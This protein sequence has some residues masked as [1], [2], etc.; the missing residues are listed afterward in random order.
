MRRGIVSQMVCVFV[1]AACGG[2]TTDPTAPPP[3][4]PPT[5]TLP[6]PTQPPVIHEAHAVSSYLIGQVA[7]GSGPYLVPLHRLLMPEV[8]PS[9][10]EA[11]DMV[12]KGETFTEAGMGVSTEIPR[13]TEL[14]GVTVADGLA[15]IDL[16]GQFDDGS[17]SMS[18][19]ARLAQV[20]YTAT[21]FDDIERVALAIESLPVTAFSAEGIDLSDPMD[22]ETFADLRNP[23][24]VEAPAWGELVGAQFTV[25]GVTTADVVS[26]ALVDW[27]GLILHE[28]SAEL[29]ATEGW[30]P[31]TMPVALSE[32][33]VT[34]H[35]AGSYDLALIV[36]EGPLEAGAQ[37][38]VVEYPLFFTAPGDA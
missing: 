10:T 12:L 21:Q 16:S 7:D 18:M 33:A 3:T 35:P 20:V 6:P 24:F 37:S 32:S 26:C 22:R 27:D 36:W 5:Q 17:G 28:V 34:P 19:R 25:A 31:F 11:V 30:H 4:S 23:V 38:H 8:E 9:V 14:L 15:T 13:D 1:L 29:P 2:T